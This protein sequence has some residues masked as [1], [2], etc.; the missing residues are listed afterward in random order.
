MG[1]CQSS[2]GS[3]N[4]HYDVEWTVLKTTRRH[5]FCVVEAG[6]A[7]PGYL[8]RS[9]RV[10]RPHIGVLTLVEREHYSAFRSK[11]AIAAE[12]AKLIA[13]LPADGVA[14]LNIDD[15][16]VRAIGAQHAGRIVWIGTGENATIRL[17]AST[18][19]WPDPLSLQVRFDG[20][21]YEIRTRLH[22]SHLALPVLAALGVAVAAGMPFADAV[23]A[24]ATIEPIQGR[25]QIESSDDGVTFVRDDWKAPHWSFQA[26]LDFMRDARARRKVV[27]IGT[28]S[29]S[30]KSPGER[31]VWAARQALEV[32]DLVVLVGGPS[33]AL[34][35]SGAGQDPALHIFATLH[36]AALYLRTEL[37]AGDLVLLKGTNQQDHLVRLLLDRQRPVQCW[38][39]ACGRNQF[40][41]TCARLYAP[42]D[43]PAFAPPAAFA[44]LPAPRPRRA[45]P[46]I[47]GLGNPGHDFQRTRH[48]VGQRV[49]D[50]IVEGAGATWQHDAEGVV[51]ALVLEGRAVTLFKPR[52]NVNDTGPVM[53]QMLDRASGT[54]DDCIVVLDDM[55]IPLGH[56]RVKHQSGDAGHKGMRSIIASLGTDAI[57]RVR[58]GVRSQGDTRPAKELVLKAFSTAEETTLAPGLGKAEDA[59]RELMRSRVDQPVS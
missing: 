52:V 47:V 23:R 57:V 3:A 55:D 22:G 41:G 27:V 45:F 5:R 2:P 32:A 7:G 43:E 6:A 40:C 49:L 21:E 25:M 13:A 59:I 34:R 44:N 58:V 30:S 50:A 16:L 53:R 10:I 18:S 35:S 24:L 8:D 9:L 51:C 15:P 33:R 12:K 54:A 19:I 26:P 11:E 4:E 48:N 38:D 28:I 1:P 37:R 36:D 39:M 29:D 17:L 46:I 31:H 20:V 14:V 42:V 56:V